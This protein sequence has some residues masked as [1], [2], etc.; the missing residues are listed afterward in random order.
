MYKE[1]VSFRLPNGFIS[2]QL[3]KQ[4]V[5]LTEGRRRPAVVMSTDMA[6]FPVSPGEESR[7]LYLLEKQNELLR[8]IF[9]SHR[10]L[11]V[12]VPSV[13]Q[14]GTGLKNWL[15]GPTMK[16]RARSQ[17]PR[18]LVVF[19]AALD[20][21]SCAVEIHRV[22]HEYNRAVP[23]EK[24]MLLRIGIHVGEFERREGEVFGDGVAVASKLALLGE[25]G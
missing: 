23:A 12:E 22:I 6:N 3:S 25:A 1:N 16:G 7:A 20:A 13:D 18:C 10:G 4:R 8:P 17:S 2:S 24:D 9:S 15:A 14:K 11:E 19:E 21:A 5:P